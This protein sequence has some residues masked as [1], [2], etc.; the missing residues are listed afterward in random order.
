MSYRDTE[1]LIRHLI[2][3]QIPSLK[4]DHVINIQPTGEW[5]QFVF[6]LDLVPQS[7]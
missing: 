4:V 7:Q 2:T 3:E 6:D 1:R 5:A